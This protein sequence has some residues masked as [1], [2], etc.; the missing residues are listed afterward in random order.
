MISFNKAEI[1]LEPWERS[2]KVTT[3]SSTEAEAD[4]M[5]LI[6]DMLSH[7]IIPTVFGS[8]LL[9]KFPN[10]V[11]E[12]IALDE[13]VPFFVMGLPIMTPWPGVAK[14]HMARRRLWSAMDEMQMQLDKKANGEDTD[15]SWGDLDVVSEFMLERN[16][17]WRGMF[18]MRMWKLS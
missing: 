1:D 8:G 5:A 10:I 13:G 11:Q 18:L 17:I 14:A 12:V 16:R 6:R 9:D 7:A 3:I 4:L 15:Y 2:S